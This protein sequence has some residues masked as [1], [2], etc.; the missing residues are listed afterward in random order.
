MTQPPPSLP[1]ND[2]RS[3][4]QL[5][6]G[7]WR[8]PADATAQAVKA[9][10]ASG[11]RH[12]DTAAIY[13]NEAGVGE[14]LRASG[15]A[16]DQ[17]FITTKLWNAEQ[18]FDSTLRAF[19]AS[20]Q[21]LG[22]DVLDLYLIHW[23]C[24]SRELYVDT[25]RAFIRLRDE[26]RVRSIGVSNFEP[27]HLDRIVQE[28]GAK[29]VLNQIELHPRFQQHRLRDYHAA[30]GIATQAWS[31]LGQGQLLE[32]VAIQAI[33]RKYGKTAA[34]VVVR[35]HIDMGHVVIPKS[36]NPGRIAENAGVFDFALDAQ[37]MAAVAKLDQAE[38][39]IGPNPLT[40]AF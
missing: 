8:T 34:Q 14:G 28:T 29:P 18:G 25:W 38:G 27:E 13:G 33:A 35:W 17:V 21:L 11:Y 24:P 5:G 15:V 30:H 6:L 39:R 16:R 12:I 20:M 22:L 37:D 7:V 40:A 32:D 31:P 9:A 36:V 3:I 19:D 23:P 4:P 10:L 26:G 2:G 1:L